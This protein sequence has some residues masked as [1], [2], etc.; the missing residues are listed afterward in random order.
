MT[1]EA[2]KS[3]QFGKLEGG[4]TAVVIRL[5]GGDEMMGLMSA[6]GALYMENIMCDQMRRERSDTISMQE[7]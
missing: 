3:I 1:R 6:R 2:L 7:R 4:K 5:N